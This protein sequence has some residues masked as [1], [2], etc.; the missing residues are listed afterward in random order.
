MQR[1]FRG[2]IPFDSTFH[3]HRKFWINLGYCINPKH[4]IP[5]SL[6]KTSLQHVTA[7]EGNDVCKIAG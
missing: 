7:Y 6:P 4:S 2:L 1:G 3:F 5:Y